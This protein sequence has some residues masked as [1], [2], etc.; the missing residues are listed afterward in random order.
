MANQ[1]TGKNHMGPLR[2]YSEGKMSNNGGVCSDLNLNG[3]ERGVR[4]LEQQQSKWGKTNTLLIWNNKD[5]THR[6]FNNYS[7][8]ILM[9]Q[10]NWI[11][12]SN[13][14]WC[15]FNIHT[16]FSQPGTLPSELDKLRSLLDALAWDGF[17]LEL[18]ELLEPMEMYSAWSSS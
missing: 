14:W 16:F 2:T 4:F 15:T 1:S 12:I 8:K 13:K 10:Y 6:W 9:Y 7:E 11:G 18:C 5:S 3:W 17:L